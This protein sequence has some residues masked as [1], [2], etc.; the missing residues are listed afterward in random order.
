MINVIPHLNLLFLSHKLEGIN[1]AKAAGPDNLAGKFLKDGASI[2]AKP[3]TE[4]CNLAISLSSFPDDFK[5]AKLKSL[6][7]KGNKDEQKVIGQSHFYRRS[8]R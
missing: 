8:P 2:L 4:I 3:V 7:K 1:P 5:Q 6:F